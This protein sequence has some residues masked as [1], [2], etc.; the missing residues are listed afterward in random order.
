MPDSET[1]IPG[2]GPLLVSV[3]DLS[4][5]LSTSERN[6]WRLDALGKIPAPL[7]IGRLRRW[8]VE[9]IH[10]WVDAGC[11]PRAKSRRTE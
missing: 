11:P 8:R 7:E 4:R 10:R 3:K 6:I 5:M 2:A 9:E 1:I